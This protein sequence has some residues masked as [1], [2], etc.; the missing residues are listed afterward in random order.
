MK[1]KDLIKSYWNTGVFDNIST[2]IVGKDLI[3]IK[4][5]LQQ[6]DEFK[7]CKNFNVL[8]FP[9]CAVDQDG[10]PCFVEAVAVGSMQ[11]V[12]VKLEPEI[13]FSDTID[14][15][16]IGTTPIMYNRQT[17]DNLPSGVW[18]LP[19]IMK[20]GTWE[21]KHEIKIKWAAGNMQDE[22]GGKDVVQDILKKVEHFLTNPN[23]INIPH[24]RGIFLRLSPRSLKNQ[25][26]DQSD[27]TVTFNE[28]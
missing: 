26:R 21:P 27:C 16:A 14:L 17:I 5:F 20:E 3:P 18:N 13:K 8:E 19:V 11:T 28:Q 7:D 4:E 22:A 10:N 2:Q 24:E 9:N 23:E 1:L 6:L 12:L 25:V 15:Y